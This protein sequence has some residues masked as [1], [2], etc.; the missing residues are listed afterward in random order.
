MSIASAIKCVI[1]LLLAVVPWLFPNAC[2]SIKMFFSCAAVA[3]SLVAYLLEKNAELKRKI[4]LLERK[5]TGLRKELLD[6]QTKHRAL[7]IQFDKKRA[8]VTKYE[9][10]V[11]YL[12]QLL[13]MA[14]ISDERVKLDTLSTFFFRIKAELLNEQNKEVK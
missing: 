5:N 10:V 6:I 3:G 9:A 12:G 7:A 13:C 4:S 14:S 1:T 8:E 2:M 11:E